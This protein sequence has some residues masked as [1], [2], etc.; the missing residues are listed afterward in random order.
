MYHFI[1]CYRFHIYQFNITGNRKCRVEP[2]SISYKRCAK[3]ISSILQVSKSAE[4]N[5]DGLR[6]LAS[7]L[8]RLEK[9]RPL[10]QFARNAG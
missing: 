3:C 8:P 7:P 9:G 1:K 2:V 4:L 5:K 10:T 6:L